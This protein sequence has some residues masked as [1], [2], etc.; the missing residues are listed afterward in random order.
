MILFIFIVVIPYA[1]VEILTLMYSDEFPNVTEDVAMADSMEYFKVMDYDDKEAEILSVCEGHSAVVL[2]KY[3]KRG[4]K[5]RL[6]EWSCVW[7]ETGSG[8]DFTWPLYR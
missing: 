5:C 6:E 7:S 1:K 3:E 8:S 4:S 2:C